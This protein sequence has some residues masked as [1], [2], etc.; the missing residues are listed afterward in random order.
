MA[1]AEF[2]CLSRIGDTKQWLC[3]VSTGRKNGVHNVKNT[4]TSYGPHG[5]LSV[6]KII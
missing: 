2:L 1:T 6:D 4:H 3:W 5:F